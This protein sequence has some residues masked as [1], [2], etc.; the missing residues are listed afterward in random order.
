MEGREGEREGRPQSSIRRLR[1]ADG[2]PQGDEWRGEGGGR[3]VGGQGRWEPHRAA[4]RVSWANERCFQYWG[5]RRESRGQRPCESLSPLSPGEGG[6]ERSRTQSAPRWPC[7]NLRRPTGLGDPSLS[8]GNRPSGARCPDPF[9][10]LSLVCIWRNA[11]RSAGGDKHRGAPEAKRRSWARAWGVRPF[12]RP[13]C[14]GVGHGGGEWL[15]GGRRRGPHPRGRLVGDGVGNTKQ[16][17]PYATGR[18][19]WAVVFR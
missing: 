15:G 18:M 12:G 8:R 7:M 11:W 5:A 10:P 17:T 16:R 6:R 14:G 2:R 13:G 4:L 9:H 3:M 19:C 1:G